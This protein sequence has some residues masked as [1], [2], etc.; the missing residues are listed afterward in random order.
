ME[1]LERCTNPSQLL[2]GLLDT[3]E[4]A[5]CILDDDKNLIIRFEEGSQY[6]SE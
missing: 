4:K 5:A 6:W 2:Y 1:Q 3:I